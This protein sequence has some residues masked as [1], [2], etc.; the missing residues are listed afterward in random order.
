[1]FLDTRK[2]SLNFLNQE[3][4]GGR[5]H[6]RKERKIPFPPKIRGLTK[7]AISAAWDIA[8]NTIK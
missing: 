2:I 4:E 8:Q 1:V 3:K 6:P 7:G 5:M